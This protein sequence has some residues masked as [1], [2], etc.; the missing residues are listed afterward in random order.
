MLHNLLRGTD[1]KIQN[2]KFKIIR[3]D[4]YTI[5]DFWHKLSFESCNSIFGSN[6]VNCVF[7]SFLIIHLR[8]FFSSFPLKKV[9]IK[10]NSHAWITSSIRA[11]CKCEKDLF[12]LCRN[13]N[14]VKLKNYYKMYCKMLSKDIK[15]AKKCHFNRLIE[16]S[17]NKMKTIWD[18]AKLLTGKK[19][20]YNDIQQI[21]TDGTLTS[22]SQIIS[23][24]FNNY[25]FYQ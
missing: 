9:T 7:N 15:E 21:N 1:I 4:T 16:N 6:Y 12:L 11:S 14:D 19:K 5:L 13:S 8:M 20:N 17:D 10:T 18:I 23:N 22:N 25:F 24:S 3:I 2:S